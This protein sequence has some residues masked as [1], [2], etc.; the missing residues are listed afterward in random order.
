MAPKLNARI[1][2][3]TALSALV[4]STT[5]AVSCNTT[6]L[7]TTTSL[8]YISEYGTTI[9]DVANA[10]NRGVCDIRRHNLMA[11]VEIIPNVGQQILI[12]PEVYEPDNET[13]ILPRQNATR[14][15]IYSVL[16]L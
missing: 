7:N 4:T 6:A 11:D 8:Y 10:T 15:C 13:C 5:A 16:R 12:P 1:A 9:L 14:T 2:T 3:L